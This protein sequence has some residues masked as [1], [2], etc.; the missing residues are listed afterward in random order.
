MYASLVLRIFYGK[1]DSIAYSFLY[2]NHKVSIFYSNYNRYL[3]KELNLLTILLDFPL[4][5]SLRGEKW[6][7]GANQA[8][9]FDAGLKLNSKTLSHHLA[10]S[11]RRSSAMGEVDSCNPKGSP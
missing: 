6:M 10:T 9:L 1:Q 8:V 5:P 7:G 11:N 4:N 3:S 2:H